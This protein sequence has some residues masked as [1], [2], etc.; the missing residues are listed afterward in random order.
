MRPSIGLEQLQGASVSGSV[1]LTERVLNELAN[2]QVSER[3][4][5][6]QQIDIQIG[7]DNYLQVGVKVSVGPF[8]K[9]FRP[10]LAIAPSMQR[11]RLVISIVS[12]QYANL[13]WIAGLLSKELLPQGI[14]VQGRDLILDFA[15][16]PALAQYAAYLRA[17]HITT[18]RGIILLSF[19]AR[20]DQ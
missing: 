10:E 9:W 15:A 19:E 17:L 4:G 3:T 2:R 11:H 1:P 14:T 13:A 20:I 8:S 12:P 6:I 7:R 18:Q 16:V 5:R